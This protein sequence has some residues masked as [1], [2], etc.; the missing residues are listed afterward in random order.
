MNPILIH[1]YVT[2]AIQRFGVTGGELQSKPDA[3]PAI[4]NPL[5]RAPTTIKT[6]QVVLLT[7]FGLAG[8][9]ALVIIV[10]SGF[11]LVTSNGD[12]EA[13]AKARNTIFYAVIG[14]VVCLAAA[15]I[16]AFVMNRIV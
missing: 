7:F 15:A 8:G 5:P 4:A 9:T 6:M 13:F 10:L 1:Y 3:I 2:T 14:L 11:R 16:V 12:P